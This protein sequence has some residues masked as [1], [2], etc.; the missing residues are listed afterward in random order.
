MLPKAPRFAAP[1]DATQIV[2]EKVAFEGES[3][4]EDIA[5]LVGNESE[6]SCVSQQAS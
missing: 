6:E 4:G 1:H 3:G 5:A 2:R